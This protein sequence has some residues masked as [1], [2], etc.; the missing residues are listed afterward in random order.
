MKI[1][2][3]NSNRPLAEAVDNVAEWDR[4]VARNK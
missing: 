4:W 1:L 2:A 3:C